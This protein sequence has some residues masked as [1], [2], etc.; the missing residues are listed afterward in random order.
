LSLSSPFINRPVATTL[1]AAALGIAGI[2]AF[3]F[4]PIASLPQVDYPAISVSAGLPGAS[5]ETMASSVATPLE[6]QLGHIAGVNE[7]TSSSSLGSTS[8][9]LQFD[10]NRNIDAAARDVQAAINAARSQ[11]PPNLP[12]NPNWS[13]N[14]PADT[15][16]LFVALRSETMKQ[17]EIYNVAIT[18]LQQKL[19]Q[20]NGVARVIVQGSSLP[21]VR[22]DVNPTQLNNAGLS[23][24]DVRAFLQSANANRPKGD[25]AN[26]RRMWSMNS[27]DQMLKADEYQPLVLAYQ[28]GAPIKLSDVATVTDSI[29]D[30]RTA[31]WA[32][33]K[34][35]IVLLIFRQPGANIVET[36][37][38]LFAL[39]PRLKASIPPVLHMDIMLD[40]S[41][42]IRDVV[43]DSETT[44]EISIVLVIFVVFVF[45]RSLRTT[46]IPAVVVPLSLGG[47]LAVLYGIGYS[48]DSLSLIA[49]TVATGFLVDDAIVVIENITRYIEAGMTPLKAALQGAQEIGPTIFS[50]SISLTAVFIPILLMT[51]YVG[52]L[53]REFA[54]TLCAAI[55]ISLFVS[56]T[57]TPMLCSRLLRDPSR[58]KRGIAYRVS[59][60]GFEWIRRVYERSLGWVLR[61]QPVM[62][63]ATLITIA[64]TGYLY[65]IIP[66]GFFPQQ[67]AGK[68]TGQVQADQATSFGAMKDR[69]VQAASII[70]KDPDIENVMVFLGGGGG[71]GGGAAVNNA[72]MFLTLKPPPA[73]KLNADQV[74]AR[75]RP[76]L[77]RVAG[78]SVFLQSIQTVR[79]GTRIVGA[80]YQYTLQS[81]SVADLNQWAPLVFQKLKTLPQL[82]DVNI[83][84]QNKG[85]QSTLVIDRGTA[86]RFGISPQMIDDTLYDA[87]GQRQVSTLYTQ[88]AQYHVVMEAEP[89]FWQDPQGL[90]FIY[91]KA[92]NGRQ[93]P[94]S[95]FTRYES[96]T[97][98][99]SVN[100][101]GQIP[102][103][104]ISFN[105]PIGAALSDAVPVIEQ[106]ERQ[107]GVPSGVRGSFSGTAQAYQESLANEPVLIAAALIT[108][109]L[110]LG[111]LYESMIHPITILSTIPSA[112]VGA[113]LAL[114]ATGNELNVI[115][116][117]GII[118][119]IGIV[120]KNAIMMIDFA[121][122]AEREDGLS[123][124][125]AIFQACVLRFRPITMT[126]VAALLGGLPMALGTGQGSEMRRPL[127]I[128][129]VGGLLFSQMLTLYTTPV[130]Y[131]YLDRFRMRLGSVKRRIVRRPVAA[132]QAGD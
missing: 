124:E 35:A 102:S 42:Q 8:I 50:I 45:L 104:T 6:R 40:T 53:F 46:F 97:A 109:Y 43:R 113:L 75:L 10:L 77:A 24:E 118:L 16:I 117:I 103:A 110:V 11:L 70:Q 95:A 128:A 48:L 63:L 131:L 12:Q 79:I 120:K 30:I 5:P 96:T 101:Q 108:V 116:L 98:P 80:Q 115:S 73:R 56:L 129:I 93:V 90:D 125:D 88:L 23:L 64:V 59:E 34:P 17:G 78:A 82:A 100:H 123:P 83:D 65:V 85:L 52:R 14:N 20:V 127:G 71:G 132:T 62:L 27:N 33:G 39:M 25:L 44:L 130:I 67:D 32:N 51:G 29:E 107:I 76:N 19:S 9:S 87:F 74:I 111:M 21:G 121:I 7:M 49:L 106:A 18:I 60:R 68:M 55:A 86:S 41:Q 58:V 38:R 66:K 119:L 105:L 13:K 57:L 26:G 69:V 3:P 15:P 72:R 99:L 89:R 4:L 122:R 22:V 1:L 94:L 37:D 126:T 47:T 84:Q 36:A 31:G 28:K 114:L 92:P 54:I 81:D 61:H 2:A 112:G 91:V